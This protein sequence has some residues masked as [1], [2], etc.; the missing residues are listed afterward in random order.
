M[1]LGVHVSTAGSLSK[2]VERAH[3]VGCEAMQIFTSNPKGWNFKVRAKEEIDLYKEEVKKYS[4][5][6]VFGH[7]IYLT[8]LAS[9]N[10][11]IYTNSINSLISGMVLANNGGLKGVITHIGSHGGAGTE[12]G[13]KKIINA[14]TQILETTKNDNTELILET[15]SGSG[16]HMGAKFE[17][18]STIIKAVKSPRLKVCID[19]CHIYVAGYDLRNETEKV[20]EEFDKTVGL[21][22]LSVLHLND[23]KGELGSNLDRHEEIGKGFIGIEAFKCIVNHPA[24]VELSGII[25]TPENKDNQATEE[26]GLDVLKALRN[27]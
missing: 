25:E 17:E 8:N 20:I 2:A 18:I 6:P 13:Y 3:K 5:E 14:V 7:A 19:T 1:K 24:L 22:N 9:Q 16:N 12:E 10:P 26:L 21:K 15:D 11:Y 23:S 27:K 4:I